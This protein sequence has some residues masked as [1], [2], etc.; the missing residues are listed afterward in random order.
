MAKSDTFNKWQV[1]VIRFK[2]SNEEDFWLWG[3]VQCVQIFSNL[4]CLEMMA[5]CKGFACI[6]KKI[7]ISALSRAHCCNQ[8]C[9]GMRE[10]LQRREIRGLGILSK[11]MDYFFE[12][13][14]SR[15]GSSLGGTKECHTRFCCKKHLL[16]QLESVLLCV[17]SVFNLRK[18]LLRE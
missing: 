8:S 18:A 10:K 13:V 2:R 9:S 12:G 3:C 1:R 17:A 6:T 16:V 5:C 11:T 4:S 15:K 7:F 14:R